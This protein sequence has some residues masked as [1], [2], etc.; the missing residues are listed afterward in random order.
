M[1]AIKNLVRTGKGKTQKKVA[2]KS[3]KTAQKTA[4]KARTRDSLRRY[5]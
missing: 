3:E 4:Q 5:G 1:A 2:K